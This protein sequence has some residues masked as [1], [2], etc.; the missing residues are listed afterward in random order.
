[1]AQVEPP[2]AFP[3]VSSW[4]RALRMESA[5]YG[6]SPLFHEP[7]HYTYS[8]N[9]GQRELTLA[10]P[11]YAY[12]PALAEAGFACLTCY[13][14]LQIIYRLR[15]ESTG[16]TRYGLFRWRSRASVSCWILKRWRR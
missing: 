7:P 9:R 14:T 4:A 1:M 5:A 15:H 3:A 12:M 6:L 10:H 8:G 2:D 13:L 11:L 16:H